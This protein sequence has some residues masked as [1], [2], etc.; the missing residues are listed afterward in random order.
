MKK[1]LFL[2]ISALL[3][4]ASYASNLSKDVI[5]KVTNNSEVSVS[6]QEQLLILEQ[7]VNT[8]NDVNAHYSHRSH[9]SHSS[10]RSHSSHYS[11]SY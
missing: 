11:S 4:G 2:L 8:G 6:D 5:A 3:T 1:V 10:H 9:Q 7:P